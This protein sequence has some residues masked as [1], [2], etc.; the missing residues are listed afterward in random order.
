MR[1]MGREYIFAPHWHWSLKEH[2]RQ[3][4]FT[5]FSTFHH[6]NW[7][8][9]PTWA[10]FMEAAAV[11]CEDWISPVT[12]CGYYSWSVLEFL[13][14]AAVGRSNID[15]QHTC[16]KKLERR[17]WTEVDRLPDRECQVLLIKQTQQNQNKRT[18]REQPTMT[19]AAPTA[20]NRANRG[21]F[22]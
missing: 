7:R 16:Q 19:R 12:F 6:N 4:S 18:I 11:S 2:I 22:A 8:N 9:I 21:T 3:I 14:S 1:S 20:R 15:K 5:P 13:P 10:T 17:N